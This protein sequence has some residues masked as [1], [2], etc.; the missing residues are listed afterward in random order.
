MARLTD[1]HRQ[2]LTQ[3]IFLRVI[4]DLAPT[5]QSNGDFAPIFSTLR[6]YLVI[7]DRRMTLPLF[8][9]EQLTVLTLL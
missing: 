3:L 8:R 2:Q 4:G 6:F 9:E 5:M 7:S 1:F